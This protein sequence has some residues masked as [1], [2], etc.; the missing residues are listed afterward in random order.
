MGVE[1]LKI[2]LRLSPAT[3]QNSIVTNPL[4][5]SKEWYQELINHLVIYHSLLLCKRWIPLLASSIEPV[6]HGSMDAGSGFGSG[7]IGSAKG[8][9][10][11]RLA[12]VFKF[13]FSSLPCVVL[14]S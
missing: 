6:I 9:A 4:Y 12:A 7:A 3:A 11:V 10:L 2:S 8:L 14:Y 13:S 1:S 5:G